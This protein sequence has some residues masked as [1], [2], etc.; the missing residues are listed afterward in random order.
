MNQKVDVPRE[1][2]GEFCR[3]HPV[4]R[5]SLYG[6][7]LRDDFRPDSDTG[8]LVDFEPG[9]TVACYDVVSA[10]VPVSLTPLVAELN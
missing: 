4:R 1:K 2:I 6:S 5:L 3:R 8:V 10:V 7:V 9:C